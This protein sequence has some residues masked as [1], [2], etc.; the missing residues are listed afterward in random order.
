MGYTPKFEVSPRLLKLLEEIAELRARI[1]NA[2]MDVP[3]IPRL[4]RDTTVREAHSSTAIEGNPLT[5]AE[6]K[7]LANEGELPH[8]KPRAIQEILNY[9]AALRFISKASKTRSI[10]EKDVLHIH[11]I[12]GQEGALDRGPFGEYRTYQVYVGAH[13]PPKA[14][15]VPRLM[16]ELIRWLN[17]PGQS[18]PGVVSSAI[19]HFRFED[20]HPF[21]D[22]NGRTG[23]ALALW[24]LYRRNLDTHHIY[25]VDEYYL[26][27]QQ[28]Y[29][30][31]LDYGQ[32][33]GVLTDWIIFCA[34]ATAES[35]RRAWK[36]IQAIPVGTDMKESIIL[37]PKQEKL[38]TL[39]RA[40]SMSIQEIMS[41]LQVTKPGAHFLLKTL[42]EAKLIERRGGYKTGRY[43]LVV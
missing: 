20:I 2:T 43:F 39:L 24:E 9:F 32:K 30:D 17:G 19:L 4:E 14:V 8:R 41:G 15:E 16:K 1:K 29:Y 13:I 40:K 7:I 25:A 42:L 37:R 3:W 11:R 34:E 28:A 5:L 23:R 21:G 26:E 6:V 33:H 10:R 31:S 38:L 22:G 27:N 12:L 18:W 36:R 35:L